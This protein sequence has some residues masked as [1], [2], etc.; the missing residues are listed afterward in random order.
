MYSTYV[1]YI[2]TRMCVCRNGENAAELNKTLIRKKASSEEGH[3]M[4][5]MKP[6]THSALITFGCE[7]KTLCMHSEAINRQTDRQTNRPISKP[8][9]KYAKQDGLTIHMYIYL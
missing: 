9:Y 1:L 4:R 3:V 7:M 5:R 8:T 6:P 2:C